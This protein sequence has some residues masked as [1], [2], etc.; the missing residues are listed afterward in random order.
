MNTGGRKNDVSHCFQEEEEEGGE[1]E[2]EMA[3]LLKQIEH[4]SG[5]EFQMKSFT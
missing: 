4:D 5:P 3:P 1:G 2:G